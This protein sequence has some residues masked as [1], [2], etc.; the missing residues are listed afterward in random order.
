MLCR[1]GIKMNILIE[2]QRVE[3]V[4]EFKYLMGSVKKH[5]EQDSYGEE[6]ICGQ[7]KT[8]RAV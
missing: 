8:S 4:D 7:K 5:P 1:K 6:S 2:G 3:E